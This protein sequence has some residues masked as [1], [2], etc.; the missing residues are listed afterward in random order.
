M[1]S[2]K[3]GSPEAG[4]AQAAP[5]PPAKPRSPSQVGRLLRDG[6]PP[7]LVMTMLSRLIRFTDFRNA[8]LF[9]PCRNAHAAC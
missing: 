2:P 5:D 1:T 8:G 7:P 6:A 3:D 9:H 4:L